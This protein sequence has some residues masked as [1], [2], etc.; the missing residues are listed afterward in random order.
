M[1]KKKYIDANEFANKLR[2][3]AMQMSYVPMGSSYYSNPGDLSGAVNTMLQQLKAEIG[4][5]IG[6][7]MS[8]MLQRLAMEVE[9]SAIDGGQCLLCQQRDGETIPDNN[10]YGCGTESA[11]VR[12]KCG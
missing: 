5:D 8:Q 2:T 9:A 7:H 6:S 10:Y 11:A 3:L 12:A 4:R 1:A